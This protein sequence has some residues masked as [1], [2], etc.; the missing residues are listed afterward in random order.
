[1]H[2]TSIICA[3]LW[4]QGEGIISLVIPGTQDEAPSCETHSP[5]T[6]LVPLGGCKI[7]HYYSTFK[8]S[9]RS[10]FCMVNNNIIM[11][12]A[13]KK[14][15]DTMP[16]IARNV[17]HQLPTMSQ[18][19]EVDCIHAVPLPP[20]QAAREK[21]VFPTRATYRSSSSTRGHDRPEGGYI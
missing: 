7:F 21:R 19:R 4:D 2:T 11:S 1:M 9:S 16:G 6:N 18:R 14:G 3:F 20:R 5:N 8:K 17:W 12:T 15:L 13:Y 10:A